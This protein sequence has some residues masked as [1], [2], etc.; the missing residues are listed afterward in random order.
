MQRVRTA[1][2]DHPRSPMKYQRLM[3]HSD[4]SKNRDKNEDKD[5]LWTPSH[6]KAKLKV[7][8]AYP[9]LFCK[10][11]GQNFQH[12]SCD[13]GF[14]SGLSTAQVKTLD[15]PITPAPMHYIA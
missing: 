6:F 13:P 15:P 2:R 14:A 8:F 10:R 9:S 12:Q 11:G 4:M 5:R 3:L 1:L 7:P